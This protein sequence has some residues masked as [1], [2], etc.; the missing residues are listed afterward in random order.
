MISSQIRTHIG[1][2]FNSNSYSN[3][4]NGGPYATAN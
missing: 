1:S 4:T 2:L 3:S